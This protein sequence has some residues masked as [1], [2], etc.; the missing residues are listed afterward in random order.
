MAQ[1]LPV[2]QGLIIIGVSRWHSDTHTHTHTHTLGRTP[3]DEWSARRRDQYLTTHNTHKI[4]T[5]MLP[6]GSEPAIPASEW[7]KT[8]R[9][10][11]SATQYSYPN[12]N[13]HLDILLTVHL[14]VIYSLFPTWYT[15]FLFT[16]NSSYL[17]SSTC[18]RPHRPIIR[19]SKLYMQ[20]MV[21]SPSADVFVV[22]PL[23][24]D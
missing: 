15:A 4:Q 1:Q 7:P 13:I 16:Y 2:G 24:K 20:P 19:R 3:L 23:R 5:P 11:G 22:R 9:P 17:L 8:A 6:A 14:S 18:F 12:I 21:F 10:L